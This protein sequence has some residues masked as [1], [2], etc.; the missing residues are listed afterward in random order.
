M[1]VPNETAHIRVNKALETYCFQGFMMFGAEENGYRP[2]SHQR[3]CECSSQL[4]SDKKK[5][6]FLKLCDMEYHIPPAPTRPKADASLGVQ[7]H[8]VL[9]V[10]NSIPTGP[11]GNRL[12]TLSINIPRRIRSVSSCSVGRNHRF[13]PDSGL[14]FWKTDCK[15]CTAQRIVSKAGSRNKARVIKQRNKQCQLLENYQ[16]GCKLF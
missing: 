10:E 5:G 1:Q 6:L 14:L 16:N 2:F 13:C 3:H 4:H 11:C 8:E 12:S 15:A 7:K 9:A